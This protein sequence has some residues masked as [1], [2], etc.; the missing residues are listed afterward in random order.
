MVELFAQDFVD[1]AVVVSD[2]ESLAG[3]TAKISDQRVR[4]LRHGRAHSLPQNHILVSLR[5]GKH[6]EYFVHERLDLGSCRVIL[7]WREIR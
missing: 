6:G 1:K 4:N 2:E 3:M 7:R 5:F